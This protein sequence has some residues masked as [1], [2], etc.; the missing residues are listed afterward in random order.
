LTKKSA[1]Q[2][3]SGSS[4]NFF[5]DWAIKKKHVTIVEPSSMDFLESANSVKRGSTE[6][7]A[8]SIGSVNST[9][10]LKFASVG[11][12]LD[13]LKTSEPRFQSKDPLNVFLESGAPY[14]LLHQFIENN[15]NVYVVDGKEVKRFRG[16]REKSDTKDAEYIRELYHQKP[17]LFRVLS[18]PEKQDVEVR[19]LMDKYNHFTKDLARFKNRQKAYERQFGENEAYG[20][21]ITELKQKKKEALKKVVPF[22]KEELEKI[23][24]KG[25]GKTLVAQIL[26]V[27]HPKD[28][29]TLSRYLAYCG[30]NAN[31]YYKDPEKGY[32]KGNFKRRYSRLAHT[33]AWQ[34]AKS[35]I[36]HKNPEWYSFYLKLKEDLKNRFPK[37]SK[38]ATH[39]KALNRLSTF[40]LKQI[41]HKLTEES[42]ATV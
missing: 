10:Q 9:P 32:V 22:I 17:K 31:C 24:I 8:N 16:D 33:T 23:N 11:E 5:V 13:S 35:C 20:N 15:F 18:E 29:S 28:F 37:N 14:L 12:L 1:P 27:A 6:N 19:F 2:T 42:D 38:I 7:E 26:S 41:Y 30:Y 36:M 3:Q 25:I 34:M 40:L 21:I 4:L 39:N